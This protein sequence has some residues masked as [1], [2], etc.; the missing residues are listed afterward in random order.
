MDWKVEVVLALEVNRDVSRSV[1][2]EI[3]AVVHIT[4]SVSSNNNRFGPVGYKSGNIVDDD[5]FS[6]DCS[7]KIVSDSS[8]GR[9]PHFLEF[10]LLYS[11]FVRSDGSTLDTDFALLNGMGGIHGDFVISFI[12]IFHSQIEVLNVEVKEGMDEFVLDELPEDSS[13]LITIKFSDGVGDFDFLGSERIGESRFANRV[14]A[15][16]QHINKNLINNYITPSNTTINFIYHP[17]APFTNTIF[18]IK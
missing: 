14:D 1:D 5:W 16:R 7:I 6:E 12:S 2:K 15:P 3:S 18:I 13:H 11:G 8:V 17:F 9:F 4:K 10:E